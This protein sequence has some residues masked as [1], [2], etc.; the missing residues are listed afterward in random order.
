MLPLSVSWKQHNEDY[1]MNIWEDLSK[2]PKV[3]WD[4]WLIV[5]EMAEIK[6]CVRCS[7]FQALLCAFPQSSQHSF[8]SIQKSSTHRQVAR[9]CI[10]EKQNNNNKRCPNWDECSIWV[11]TVCPLSSDKRPGLSFILPSRTTEWR[12]PYLLFHSAPRMD[13]NNVNLRKCLHLDNITAFGSHMQRENYVKSPVLGT[14]LRFP[15]SFA[16]PLT[17]SWDPAVLPGELWLAGFL[18]CFNPRMLVNKRN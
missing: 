2:A 16:W 18:L 3:C 14:S 15:L 12:V 6:P 7:V 9:M 13:S 17:S 1:L 11:S 10:R 8:V 4:N 5:M